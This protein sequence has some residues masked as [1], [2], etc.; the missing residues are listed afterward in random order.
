MDTVSITLSELSASLGEPRRPIVLDVRREA[1]F[2]ADPTMIAAALRPGADPVAY[3]A[4]HAHGAP[5]VTYCVHGHAVSQEAAQ[6]LRAAGHDARYLEGG[7]EAWREAGHATMRRMPQWRVPGGSRWITRAR[8]KIDR[9]ACPWL[10]RRF[11]DPIATFGYVPTERVFA[12]ADARS[13][14]PYDIPGAV[15]THRGERCSFDALIE[16]FELRHPALD[17]LATIVR[18][19]DTDRL[20]L[21]PQ[22]AGLLATSLGLSRQ[23][24]NDHEMLEAAMPVYDGLFAWCRQEI[25]GGNERHRWNPA[26]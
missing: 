2:D 16:D 24:A 20:D 17:L 26:A 11:L 7:I 6:R 21:A 25:A 18:G 22:C 9:I 8:P 19:A 14:V 5:L 13:A 15:V 4:Q 12:E 10:V 3:A 23:Y 1:A